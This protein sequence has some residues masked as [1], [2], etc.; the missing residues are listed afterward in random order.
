M[1]T[2]VSPRVWVWETPLPELPLEETPGRQL[3]RLSPMLRSPLS[4]PFRII[5]TKQSFSFQTY[6]IAAPP[7]PAP[8]T[9]LA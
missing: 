4:P 1:D 6:S 8:R 3:C 7:P 9:A 2:K 5:R